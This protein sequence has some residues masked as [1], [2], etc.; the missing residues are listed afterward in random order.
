M[1]Y[2]SEPDKTRKLNGSYPREHACGHISTVK[3]SYKSRFSANGLYKRYGKTTSLCKRCKYFKK[4]EALRQNPTDDVHDPK[5]TVELGAE[6]LKKKLEAWILKKANGHPC[7]ISAFRS[8]SAYILSNFKGK[9]FGQTVCTVP[10][11]Y[12]IVVLTEYEL[13]LKAPPHIKEIRRQ[14]NKCDEAVC[15]S[16]DLSLAVYAYQKDPNEWIS[17]KTRIYESEFFLKCATA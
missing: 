16:S 7:H 9:V 13:L 15:A 3:V 2:L 8:G 5:I 1:I 17:D 4:L 6:L 14:A 12:W 11:M 10:K